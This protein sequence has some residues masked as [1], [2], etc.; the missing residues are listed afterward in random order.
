MERI[1]TAIEKFID[2]KTKLARQKQDRI[3]RFNKLNGLVKDF[4]GM[5]NDSFSYEIGEVGIVFSKNGVVVGNS[6]GSVD[7]NTISNKNFDE[8]VEVFVT[9]VNDCTKVLENQLE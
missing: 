7:V 9:Y 3:D 5:T 2:A 4:M 8:L 1:T 6:D